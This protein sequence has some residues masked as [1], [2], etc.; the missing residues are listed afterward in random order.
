MLG[1][2]RTRKR[3]RR[4]LRVKSCFDVVSGF[5]LEFGSVDRIILLDAKVNRSRGE[6]FSMG[7][8]E[9]FDLCIDVFLLDLF[10]GADRVDFRVEFLQD[11]FYARIIEFVRAKAIQDIV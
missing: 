10:F 11:E 2:N 6:S 3:E 7:G 5:G 8:R 4:F 9:E 1:E